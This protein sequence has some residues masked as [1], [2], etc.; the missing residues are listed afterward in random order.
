MNRREL[1][2]SRRLS[3]WLTS[4]DRQGSTSAAPA[5][6]AIE[7]EIDELVLTG[8]PRSQG[9]GIAEAIRETLGRLLAGEQ[10]PWRSSEGTQVDRLD[11][12]TV[13]LSRSGRARSAGEQVARAI[14]RSL[15]K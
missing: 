13:H 7:V 2:K 15:P 8:F 6:Q 10:M 11:A 12:G 4:E 14:Y 5:P 9:S 3:D 1:G